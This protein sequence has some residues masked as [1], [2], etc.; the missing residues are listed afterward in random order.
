MKRII[1]V[2]VLS[3]VLA[4]VLVGQQQNYQEL[5]LGLIIKVA[6]SFLPSYCVAACCGSG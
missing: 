4:S 3:N 2:A 1:L 6:F 5:V